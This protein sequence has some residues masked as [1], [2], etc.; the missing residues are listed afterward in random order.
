MALFLRPPSLASAGSGSGRSGADL[1][2]LQTP[3][4]Q[5][6]YDPK[7]AGFRG[8][9]GCL[10]GFLL[11]VGMHFLFGIGVDTIPHYALSGFVAGLGVDGHAYYTTKNAPVS[12]GLTSN[13]DGP[14]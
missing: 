2:N 7:I 12:T 6:P 14:K 4:N 11:G 10:A 13:A 8:L 9:L 1:P 3:M 5:L